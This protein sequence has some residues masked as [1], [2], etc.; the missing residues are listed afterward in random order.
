[1]ETVLKCD[2]CNFSTDAID[3]MTVHEE[4][5]TRYNNL[6]CPLCSFS[7]NLKNIIM[8]HVKNDHE[9]NVELQSE[10]EYVRS[11]I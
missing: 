5:H 2:S 9:D 4:C 8:F 6:K 11:F 10:K 7:S 1:M 3:K